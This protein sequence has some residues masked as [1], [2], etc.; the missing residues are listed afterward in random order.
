VLSP[1]EDFFWGGIDAPVPESPTASVVL[2]QE[3]VIIFVPNAGIP[4]TRSEH[5]K[6]EI[7]GWRIRKDSQ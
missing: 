4:E 1:S 7:A 6:S 5:H 3:C 2:P